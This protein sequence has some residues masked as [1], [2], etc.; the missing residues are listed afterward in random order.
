VQFTIAVDFDPSTLLK[1]GPLVPG[2][3]RNG[4]NAIEGFFLIDTGA[5]NIAICE[6]V[7]SQLGLA[8]IKSSV[9]HGVSGAAKVNEYKVAMHVPVLDDQ[10]RNV[11]FGIPVVAQGVPGLT[12]NHSQ[13][14][15]HVIGLLGRVFLQ[16]AAVTIEGE[17]GRVRLTIGESITRPR[18]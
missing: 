4:E 13:F 15:R 3:W 8:P 17:S 14:G 5:A 2:H 1:H 10:Q 7:A 6:T 12:A 9:V 11:M 16:F 18:P